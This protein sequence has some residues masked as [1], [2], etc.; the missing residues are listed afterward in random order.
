MKNLTNHEKQNPNIYDC[1]G[2]SEMTS[3]LSPFFLRFLPPN[4]EATKRTTACTMA[5][6]LTAFSFFCCCIADEGFELFDV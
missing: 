5:S 4:I 1:E 3:S 6:T 2:D